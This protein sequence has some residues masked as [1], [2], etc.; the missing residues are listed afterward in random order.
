MRLHKYL[1]TT[2]G[3]TGHLMIKIPTFMERMDFLKE[4]GL[5]ISSEGTEIKADVKMSLDL[6]R[7][8]YSKVLDLVQEVHLK[9][10]D[11]EI[12]DKD[13]LQVYE[14]C[15]PLIMEVAEVLKNGLSL[16]K[17]QGPQ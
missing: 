11:T 3:F 14:E 8:M 17:P 16:G 1:P 10:G 4:M 13:D 9:Y 5:D 15:L 6:I 7:M 12:K 2:E